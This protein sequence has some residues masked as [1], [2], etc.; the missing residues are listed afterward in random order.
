MVQQYAS[1]WRTR[2]KEH[3]P[4][5]DIRAIVLHVVDLILVSRT[6]FTCPHRARTDLGESNLLF[7][8]CQYSSM[9]ICFRSCFA[10]VLVLQVYGHRLIRFSL[11]LGFLFLRCPP[12]RRLAWFGSVWFG[13]F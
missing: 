10:F 12:A 5:P 11:L 13:L 8:L 1:M 9:E 7:A 4:E 6:H 3:G 2:V